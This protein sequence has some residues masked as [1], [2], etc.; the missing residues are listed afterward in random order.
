MANSWLARRIR[1]TATQ[2]QTEICLFLITLNS[3][4]VPSVGYLLPPMETCVDDSKREK[5]TLQ[6]KMKSFR[7]LLAGHPS[8]YSEI[9]QSGATCSEY[10]REYYFGATLAA[11][12]EEQYQLKHLS[13]LPHRDIVSVFAT[14]CSI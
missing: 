13:V 1:Y 8:W 10:S 11:A 6:T 5:L 4:Y 7:Y 2:L 9:Q 14:S 12:S 3:G